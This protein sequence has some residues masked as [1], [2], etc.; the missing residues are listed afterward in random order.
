M[1]FTLYNAKSSYSLSLY[2]LSKILLNLSYDFILSAS[3]TFNN[4]Y[5]C[6]L[7]VKYEFFLLFK[8]FSERFTDKIKKIQEECKKIIKK[9]F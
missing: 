3:T 6:H 1:R 5:K 8:C 4:G 7:D 2:T 9:E